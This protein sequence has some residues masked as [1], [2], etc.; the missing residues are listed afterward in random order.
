[1]NAGLV[2]GVDV[3]FVVQSWFLTAGGGLKELRWIG[4]GTSKCHLSLLLCRSSLKA[5]RE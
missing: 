3:V 2:L 5:R 1:V 4:H